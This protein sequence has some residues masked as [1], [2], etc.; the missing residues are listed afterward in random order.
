M[1][2]STLYQRGKECV[3]QITGGLVLAFVFCPVVN[4]EVDKKTKGQQ[5]EK[6][7]AFAALLP[8]NNRNECKLRGY[9]PPFNKP[10]YNR[11]KYNKC[12]KMIESLRGNLDF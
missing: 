9:R 7:S 1:V 8:H 11:H 10:P 5:A 4:A 12:L 6:L 3:L 2:K